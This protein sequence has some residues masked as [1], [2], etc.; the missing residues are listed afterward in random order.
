MDNVLLNE[1]YKCSH[2]K[3]IHDLLERER[4][5]CIL[6]LA[7]TILATIINTLYFDEDRFDYIQDSKNNI[8][9][10][11]SFILSVNAI[12]ISKQ[13]KYDMCK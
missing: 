3:C 13:I 6:L 9:M 10:D 5:R 11:I 7:Y 8:T 4:K 12:Q 1:I 2:K